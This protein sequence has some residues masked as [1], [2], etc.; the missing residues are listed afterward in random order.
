L[1]AYNGSVG[2]VETEKGVDITTFCLGYH[3]LIPPSTVR[4]ISVEPSYK[5]DNQ[6]LKQGEYVCVG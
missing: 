6:L 4:I 3:R 2:W 5:E 1:I